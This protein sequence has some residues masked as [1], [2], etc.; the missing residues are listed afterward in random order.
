MSESNGHPLN[1]TSACS[2]HCLAQQWR[3]CPPRLPTRVV[4]RAFQFHL[5]EEVVVRTFVEELQDVFASPE[6]FRQQSPLT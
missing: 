4:D 1:E 5:H 6:Q 3:G 2:C